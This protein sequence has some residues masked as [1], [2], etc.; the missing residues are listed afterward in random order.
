MAFLI[1][2]FP[3]TAYKDPESSNSSSS[4][5]SSSF[6]PP[7]PVL[8]EDHSLSIGQVFLNQI[9]CRLEIPSVRRSTRPREETVQAII[10][11][12]E[13]DITQSNGPLFVKAKL[14]DK[15]IMVP[16]LAVTLRDWPARRPGDRLAPNLLRSG[17]QLPLSG[18]EEGH[19]LG[20]DL[21][22]CLSL[23]FADV[24]GPLMMVHTVF[25]PKVMFGSKVMA[26]S[27][28][29]SEPLARR[30]FGEQLGC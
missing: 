22:K 12:V 15:L 17:I 21:L 10:D 4:D 16:R 11:E 6:C 28:E 26:P 27:A 23:G 18:E 25:G 2:L 7:C 29:W 24:M 30:G 9:E 19:N 20:Q 13:Q 14:K 5:S 3:A 1:Q 8:Y